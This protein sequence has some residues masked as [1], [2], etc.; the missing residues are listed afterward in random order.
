MAEKRKTHKITIKMLAE[1][2]G[3]SKSTIYQWEKQKLSL[4]MLGFEMKIKSGEIAD[5]RL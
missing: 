5:P 4:A 3:K 2:L 1:Y